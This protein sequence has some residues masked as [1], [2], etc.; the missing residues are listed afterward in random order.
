MFYFFNFYFIRN[1]LAISSG[2]FAFA[3]IMLMTGMV[4]IDEIS[5]I[6]GL[7]PET[8]QTLQQIY[9]S[10]SQ[11]VQKIINVFQELIGR[12]LGWSTEGSF[13][14]S[15]INN[16]FHSNG[17]N[18]GAVPN[19]PDPSSNLNNEQ[20]NPG[21]VNS[22]TLNSNNPNSNGLDYSPASSQ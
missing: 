11:P 10:F 12:M 17:N 5:K 22:S 9:A 13:D 3:F 6:L 2:V 1:I 8:T 21:Q 19:A 14:K 16:L 4:T 15:K 20:L 7:S 18:P